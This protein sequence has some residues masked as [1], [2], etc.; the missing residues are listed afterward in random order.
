MKKTVIFSI[1]AIL[2]TPLFI[3]CGAKNNDK[4]S[5]ATNNKDSVVNAENEKSKDVNSKTDALFT[6]FFGAGKF[7]GYVYITKNDSIILDK[8]YGKADFEKGISNTAQT[9]FDLASLTKQFTALSIMQLQEKKLLNVNDKIDKY[10]PQFPHGNEIT[11]HQ[12]LNHTSGLPEHPEK[13]D[14]RKFRPSNKID[15]AAAKK[16]EVTLAFT[17]GSSFSYSNTGYILLGY[18]IEKTSGK[19]LDAYFAENIFSPLD[20]K[21][22]GFKNENSSIDN[23]AVGYLSYKKDKAETSWTET[24]V[25]V[26]RGSSGLCSTV[27]DLIK[28]DKALTNKK[29]INKESYD[30]MYTPYENNYGYGW[31]VYKDSN[32]KCYYEHYG[33]GTGYRSYILRNVEANTTAIIVSN[34]GD[35]PFGEIT[36][37]LK[38]YIK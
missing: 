38:D 12:L 10:L 14:I 32:E 17:P 23:L 15:N 6:D 1:I 25:G 19:T 11:I 30:K 16:M 35:V 37:L 13:F 26:V 29:L 36:S 4:S 18:I 21:N 9:K 27:E 31:Y 34:F 33:V 20:M 24:N 22:T 2:S 28:W 7:S 8:G 3:G 5:V